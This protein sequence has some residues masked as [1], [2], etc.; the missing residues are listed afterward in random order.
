MNKHMKSKLTLF[1]VSMATA[2]LFTSPLQAQLIS[3][4]DF[5]APDFTGDAQTP[6][7][8]DWVY[9]GSVALAGDEDDSGRVPGSN[10]NQVARFQN[11]SNG[12]LAQDL[13]YNWS[14][15]DVYDLSFNASETW[16]RSGS[17]GDE[18]SVSLLQ[19]NGSEMDL[20]GFET[21]DIELWFSGIIDLDGTHT[22]SAM[23]AWTAGQTFNYTIDA[24]TDFSGGTAGEALYIQFKW[25][26]GGTS[27]AYLDN[28]SLSV[29]PEPSALSLILAACFAL[30]WLRLRRRA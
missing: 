13:S 30:S 8:T 9:S 1:L 11:N 28:A 10:P 25:E 6:S 18:I 17:A 16:W 2:A 27:V 3:N 20:A 19:L 4:G 5:E 23:P 29:V 24:G 21:D 15:S 26:D 14:A 12:L 22:G 7:F